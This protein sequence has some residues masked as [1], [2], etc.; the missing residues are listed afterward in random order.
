MRDLAISICC[1][2]ETLCSA[3]KDDTS[4]FLRTR[5]TSTFKAPASPCSNGPLG[6]G[7]ESCQA[8]KHGR[9][10]PVPHHE[11]TGR[12]NVDKTGIT[13]HN[14]G[15]NLVLAN[16]NNTAQCIG[17]TLHSEDFEADVGSTLT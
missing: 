3:A 12:G 10:C 6:F 1:S 4:S 16:D 8:S 9:L 17:K 14:T 7:R 13:Q 2:R 5:S 15:M 11:S